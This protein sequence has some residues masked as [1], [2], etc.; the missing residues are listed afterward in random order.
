MKILIMAPF[1]D[2]LSTIHGVTEGLEQCGHQWAPLDT[3]QGRFKA[4]DPRFGG[5]V[6]EE[7][8]KFG[9]DT[10]L[11]GKATQVPLGIYSAM[12]KRLP[13]TTYLTFDSVSGNGCGPPGRPDEVGPRGLMCDRIILTGSEGA[14]WFRRKGFRGRIA[15]IYQGCR[16]SIWRPDNLDRPRN[17]QDVV[18]FLGSSNYRGDGGRRAKIGALRNSGFRIHYHRRT[19]QEKASELYYDSG[20]CLSLV[21]G[22]LGEG[23]GP[24]GITSNRLVRILTSGG[25][26]LTERNT[27]VEH[28]FE[29]G[30]QLAMTNFK[31]IPQLIEKARYYMDRPNE[32]MEIARRGWEWSKD[33]GWDKQMDKM[34]RFIDGENVDADG[35]AGNWV[36][37]YNDP[38]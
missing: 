16:H 11:I 22:A 29:D 30:N 25:F 31:D 33:W 28:T 38:E 19:F 14:R 26:A 8:E 12:V 15:Q 35:A 13:D 32:R 18:S 3:K 6:V 7:A 27:D 4:K 21:C 24:V 1:S 10:V 20:I 23:P 5:W 17:A 9:A 37:T 2:K 36:G 34:V